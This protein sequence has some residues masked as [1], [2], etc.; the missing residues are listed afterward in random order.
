MFRFNLMLKIL[1]GAI[2]GAF[3][4]CKKIVIIQIL[5]L[6]HIVLSYNHRKVD[7]SVRVV[8]LLQHSN[9]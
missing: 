6:I 4:V 3:G 9:F 1:R 2:G 8:H 5:S 7:S